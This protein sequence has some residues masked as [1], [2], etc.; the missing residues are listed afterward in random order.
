MTN[1]LISDV[2]EIDVD[3]YS[4]QFPELVRS[5]TR[6]ELS[7]SASSWMKQS[8]MNTYM[9]KDGLPTAVMNDTENAQTFSVSFGCTTGGG[10]GC[11]AGRE[12]QSTPIADHLKISFGEEEGQVG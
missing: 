9:G 12:G 1:E 2:N 4:S 6:L 11:R 8:V 7:T 10:G 3:I 5:R